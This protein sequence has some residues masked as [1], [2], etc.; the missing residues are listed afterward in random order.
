MA[1]SVREGQ[2]KVQYVYRNFP[3]S[4]TFSRNAVRYMSEIFRAA[5]VAPKRMVVMY[6]NDLFGKTVADAFQATH[7]A[8]SPGFDIVQVIPY[9]E[10]AVDLSNEVAL[11]KS[12]KPDVIAPLTRPATAILL[13]EELAR[14]RVDLMGINETGDNPNASTA[15]IQILGQRPRVVWPKESAEQAFVFP[16]PKA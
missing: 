8:M 15:A 16:R 3:S 5:G 1:K 2:Q 10:A 12:A 11:A 14:Q 7:K 9:P 13:L 6:T 4:G